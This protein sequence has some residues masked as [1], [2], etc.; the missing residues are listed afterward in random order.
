MRPYGFVLC[1][2]IVSC[3]RAANPSVTLARADGATVLDNG[4]LRVEIAERSAELTALRFHGLDLLHGGKG[5]WSGVGQPKA[6]RAAAPTFEVAVDPA[7]N[8]GEMA[9]VVT[10]FRGGGPFEVPLDADLHYTLRRGAGAVYAWAVLRHGAG[11]P[12]FDLGEARLCLK[13]NPGVFNHLTVD[14]RRDLDMASG[15]DWD[16]GEPLNLKEARR[17]TTGPRRGEV[18]HKYDYSA[19]L[20]DTPAY[21]WT[22]TRHGVGLWLINPSQE[23]VSGGPTKVELTGH[24]DGNRGGLPTLLNMWQGSHYGSRGIRVA[25]GETWS[26]CIGPFLL[27]C[28]SAEKAADLWPEALAAAAA[29]QRQWPY[30][31]VADPD[32]P[33]AT[34]RGSVTGQLT[35][36]DP[37]DAKATGAN[38]WVGLTLAADGDWQ[39]DSK[40][41]QY[42]ARAD[43]AGRFRIASARPGSY[44]LVAFNNGILGELHRAG[45]AVT[46]G[47]TNE[48]GGVA[49]TPQRF[50]RQL[51]DIGVP[52]RSAAEFRHGDDYWHWGLYL[53]YPEEFSHDVDY[54][55]G[56]SDPR[57]DW[58]YCQPPR[59]DARGH[60]TD[61]TWRIH[62]DRQTAARGTCILRL[63]FCGARGRCRVAVGVNGTSVG[64]SG[65]LPED[66][67]MHRDGIRGYWFERDVRFD[68]ALLKAGD[69][70][71]SLH[72]VARDWTMGVLYDYVRLE[73]DETGREES[74]R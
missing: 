22:S 67:V 50:G 63:A 60:V 53:R 23:Y 46:A 34:A 33:P 35:V 12:G 66:G 58:N 20:A 64:D 25:D 14:P 2:A 73:L 68:A 29:E 10:H 30:A 17:L 54:V 37:E 52:D 38:A 36:S 49:W 31:W 57:T 72:S 15:A 7:A 51:W 4:L 11:Q 40:H 45:V 59:L 9:D 16:A 26:K 74:Q 19:L 69:N 56:R 48:L 8:G 70:V 21:G 42:W 32:Y 47:G 62:F 44:L 3:A 5:Y 6:G 61:S 18:E 39:W 28:D 55:I 71:I 65:E 27:Y 13:L 43:D 41:Y 24:L 1:L